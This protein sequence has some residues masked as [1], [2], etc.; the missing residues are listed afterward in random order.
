[1]GSFDDCVKC[2]ARGGGAKKEY[3][4]SAQDRVSISIEQLIGV[5]LEKHDVVNGIVCRVEF[6]SSPQLS[7]SDRLGEY[8]KVLDFV[9]ADPD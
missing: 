7:P 3:S 5:L 9:M 2:V 1:M 4:P 6:N 8:A